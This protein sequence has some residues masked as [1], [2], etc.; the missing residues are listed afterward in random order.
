MCV[1]SY[2]M[3]WQGDCGLQFQLSDTLVHGWILH[4]VSLSLCG[5]TV[6]LPAQDQQWEDAVD[7]PREE[8]SN[9]GLRQ[10]QICLP[11][12]PVPR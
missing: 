1:V 10:P 4:Q 3:G 8:K 2:K 5:Y 12:N 6:L 7:A 9:L 11:P